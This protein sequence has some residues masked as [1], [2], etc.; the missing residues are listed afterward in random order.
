MDRQHPISPLAVVGI[1]C[2]LPGGANDTD[3][4]WDLL[5]DG[6]DTWSPVPEDRFNES[7]FHHPSPDDP[8]GSNNHRGGHFIDANISSFD[9]SFFRISPQ[10]AAV[11]DPQQR[12]LLEMTYEALESAGM[13]REQYRGS[14]TGVF[15]ALFITDFDRN[16]LKDTIGKS[17]YTLLGNEEAILT[18]RI[19]H[20]LDL[21][22]PSL[23][24]DT[25]CSGGMVALHQAC[26]ALR[27]GECETAIVVSGNITLSPDHTA[28]MAN[29]HFLNSNGR[30]YPFDSRGDG[31]G[32]GEGFVAIILKRMQDAIDGRFPVQAVIRSTAINQD[33]Y[34]PEGITYPNSKAQ[35]DLIRY[36]YARAG[37]RPQDVSY[38]EAHGTGTLAGDFQELSAISNT[39]TGADRS[40]PL[41]IGSIK[42]N[43]GHT[44]NTSGLAGLLKS[45]LVLQRKEIPPLACFEKPKPGLPLDHINLPTTL[46]PLPQESGRLSLVSVNSFGFGGT[47]GHAILEEAP[48]AAVSSADCSSNSSP[49]LFRFS[50]DCKE[51]LLAIIRNHQ[52][53]LRLHQDASLADFSYTLCER[54]TAFPWR[55]SCVAETHAQLAQKLADGAADSIQATPSKKTSVAYVFTGQGAQWIGMGRE[56]MTGEKGTVSAFCA[57][58]HASTK[59]LL[60][61]G[62]TW[63]L[64]A[65][66]SGTGAEAELINTAELAQPVTTA[67]QRHVPET[68]LTLPMDYSIANCQ[69]IKPDVVIGHSSGEI[70]AAYTA[71]YLSHHAALAVAFHRGFMAQTAKSKDWPAGGMMSVGLGE[72]EA[73]ELLQGLQSGKAVTACVN[74]PSNV[75]ISGDTAA[76]DE[77]SSILQANGNGT[78]HRR[79]AVD[80]AYHSHHMQAV[81]EDYRTRLVGLEHMKPE[82]TTECPLFISSVTGVAKSSE[83]GI[84]YWIDNL[85]SP[86]RFCDA[87]QTASRDF[88][89]ASQRN[90]HVFFVEIGPH[91][92]LAGPVRQSLGALPGKSFEFDYSSVLQRKTSAVVSALSLLGGFFERD[93]PIASGALAD[94]TPRLSTARVCPDLPSYAWDHSVDHWKEFRH[95]SEHRFRRHPYHDLLGVRIP[96]SAGNEP[97]WRHVIGLDT[98][99]WLADHIIDGLSIFPG[100][101]YMCMAAEGVRQIKMDSHPTK[102]LESLVFRQVSFLRALVIP[103]SGQVEL[104]LRFKPRT[105][106][107]LDFSFSIS[108]LSDGQWNE[109]C[110]GL[111][112]GLLADELLETVQDV[113]QAARAEPVH[114]HDLPASQLYET[115][116]TAGNTYGPTFAAIR[117]YNYT[118][119]DELQATATVTVPDVAATMRARYQQPHLIHPT[120]L[121]AILHSSLPVAEKRLGSGS[122]MPVYIE[123][124]LMSATS[125]LPSEP[126]SELEVKTKISSGHFRTAYTDF[127]V[128]AGNIPVM[129]ISGAEMRKVGGSAEDASQITAE[130]QRPVCFQVEWGADQEFLRAEDIEVN[131]TLEQLLGH[132]AFKTPGLSVLDI[133]PSRRANSISVADVIQGH[134]GSVSIYDMVEPAAE[135]HGVN[136]VNGH[137]TDILES[138]KQSLRSSAYDLILITD[139][140]WIHAASSLIKPGGVLISTLELTDELP[141]MNSV[142]MKSQLCFRDNHLNLSITMLRP[143]SEQTMASSNTVQVICHSEESSISPWARNLVHTLPSYRVGIEG[144]P[145]TLNSMAVAASATSDKI[146]LVIED[147]STAILSDEKYFEAGISLLKQPARVVWINSEKDVRMHQITGV[148]R[149]AHAENDNLHATTIHVGSESPSGSRF[150]ELVA[151]AVSKVGDSN[152]EREYRVL[153]NGTIM[154]PRLRTHDGYTNAIR[155]E[156]S[157]TCEIMERP[158]TDISRPVRL[159]VSDDREINDP[160]FSEEQPPSA[161]ALAP[162]EVQ[163]AVEYMSLAKSYG[164]IQLC[165]YVGTVAR[166]GSSVNHFTIGDT[167]VALGSSVGSS[168]PYMPRAHVAR[169][170]MGVP[171]AKASALLLNAM[172]ATYSLRELA[173]LSLGDAV[174]IHGAATAAGRAAISAAK[175]IGLRI[176]CTAADSVDAK[177]LQEREGFLAGDIFVTRPSFSRLS[178]EQVFSVAVDA[179]IIATEASLPVEIMRHLRPGGSVI[180]TDSFSHQKSMTTLPGKL[181]AN[182]TLYHCN[183]DELLAACPQM[184]SSLLPDAVATLSSVSLDGLDILVNDVS[185]TA[186]VL[187]LLDSNMYSKAVIQVNADSKTSVRAMKSF[188]WQGQEVTFVVSGGLGD[189]GQRCLKIL[190]SRGARSL[191]TLSRSFL[192]PEKLQSLERAL[193][194]IQPGC[195]LYCIECD[196]SIESNV[197]EAAQKI[198]DLGLPPVCGII[199]SSTVLRDST[200]E[201]I[202]FAD[203]QLTSRIKVDGSMHLYNAMSSPSLKFFIS[204]SSVVA[205]V[206]TSGQAN[207][208]AGNAAQDIMS[209]I[210]RGDS[211]HFT[212]LNIGWVE[213]SHLTSDF[214]VRKNAILRAGLTPVGPESLYKYLDYSFASSATE[215]HVSQIAIGIEPRV[216]AQSIA[217]NGTVYSPMF[218]HVLH[219]ITDSTEPKRET[220]A[221]NFAQVAASGDIDIIID[222]IATRFTIQLAKLIYADPSTI[223]RYRTSLL[224]LGLD[225]LIAIELR[226]WIQREFDTRLQSSE[227]FAQQDVYTLAEKIA[228]RSQVVSGLEFEV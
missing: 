90:S 103:A 87:V 171:P 25:G 158:I 73:T 92:A 140:G 13:P 204:M 50:A 59:I 196:I 40:L 11:M 177:C 48:K 53:W 141:S 156:L 179:V 70:A 114:G 21:H 129:M 5:K 151:F 115:L 128:T 97:Q 98:L 208:S 169:L 192:T 111:I 186:E 47:N 78:F 12:I 24:L 135:P 46:S 10:Q 100:S 134:R 197:K 189:L 38:I 54:R 1:S 142:P 58:I 150:H 119:D 116:K 131:P 125:E 66:L 170:P 67:L 28:E 15:G 127:S 178:A 8:N 210:H 63:N 109:N 94:L 34:T 139:S 154:V 105:T 118:S 41:F 126:G 152:R 224:A 36:T 37:L 225:S 195:R 201:T 198:K 202:S 191:V 79:L 102:K 80:T 184:I 76:L 122:I 9:A 81:A 99:P 212:S 190:A 147:Q 86:V 175:A 143:S 31:Y 168:H 166:I 30:S 133:G 62:A 19:S 173:K 42:G 157:D 93:V 89:S 209:Q 33:G 227:I 61:L 17:P 155:A 176:I 14:N 149:T 75:T 27:S 29:L 222:F 206:G 216:I 69:G 160:C 164:S 121:D 161:R 45:I 120:T 88:Y 163:L 65:A 223:D 193:E 138:I 2:R 137:R 132:I 16:M 52:S 167:V 112:E 172:A 159:H 60:A 39:F 83:F 148:I 85:V 187:K 56:L 7:A 123:E 194:D 136:G 113:A 226:N 6:V 174:L 104:Y 117:S 18:N 22:G 4:L 218:S 44:E 145:T 77:I 211:C 110:T 188:M 26:N 82:E 57:S 49:L 72:D 182:A 84:Q 162:D 96:G 228:A 221:Q 43:I 130:E 71:G 64:E 214:D 107:G 213:D 153:D 91:P 95:S 32:R 219:G 146:M 183:I 108:T 165:E 68:N 55:F 181:S 180:L 51:S 3:K 199:Q 106:I 220:T 215:D 23:T 35:E 203:Y 144:A 217:T 20:A 74:S 207:Y 124:L 185:K 205:V 101:G 200:L